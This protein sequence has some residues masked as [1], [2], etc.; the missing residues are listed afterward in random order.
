MFE[1]PNVSV[2][3]F[4]PPPGWGFSLPVVYAVWLC[5]VVTLYPVC[6]W[7]A[8]VKQRRRDCVVEL[9]VTR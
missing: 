6:A 3:P 7:F 4:T 2:Y 9:F 5:V 8:S 1:S